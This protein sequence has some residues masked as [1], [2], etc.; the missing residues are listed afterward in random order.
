MER[1]DLQLYLG[2]RRSNPNRANRNTHVNERAFRKLRGKKT[3]LMDLPDHEE[4]KELDSLPPDRLRIELLKKGINPYKDIS[5]RVW[6]EAQTTTSSF[7]AVI[8]PYV[9]LEEKLPFWTN[10]PI[11]NG[12]AKFKELTQ[13]G[14]H[15]WHT[16]RNGTRR[17]KNKEGFASFS[18]KTFGPTAEHVYVEAHKALMARNRPELL[19]LITEHAFQKMWPDVDEGSIKW[20]LVE[21]LEPHQVV[22]VRCSDMPYQSGNDIAQVTVRMHTKQKLALY[23]RFGKLILGSETQPREVVE[24]VVFENHIAVVDGTW[25]L[26]DKDEDRPNSAHSSKSSTPSERSPQSRKQ[27][28][29]SSDEESVPSH[30]S[31]SNSP[32]NDH[33]SP[34]KKR[35]IETSDEEDDV[36]PKQSQ[37][38]QLFGDDMS[39]SN[40][41]ADNNDLEEG[42][43]QDHEGTPPDG[44]EED[45]TP[46]VI[47]A[48]S[49][50]T[51]I[52]LGE[53]IVFV[54]LPNF[55]SLEAKAFDPEDFS[56][57]EEEL[58]DEEGRQRLKLK[59]ENTIRWRKVAKE[60]GTEQY[61]SNSKIVKWSDGTMSLYLGGEIFDIEM[62][63]MLDHNHLYLRQGAG[64]IGQG[65]FDERCTFRPHSTDSK[66]HRKVTMSMAERTR[67]GA[68][69]KMIADSGLN[70]EKIR[71][72]TVRKEEE[73][74]RQA[75]RAQFA[76]QARGRR[77]RDFR[78]Y[79]GEEDD[80]DPESLSSIKR[81]YQD[82][83]IIGPSESESETESNRGDNQNNSSDSDAEFRRNKAQRKKMIVDDDSD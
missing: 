70:P 4:Q 17:I 51:D 7:Y 39:S 64:L 20:E 16:Y 5:P 25:R 42:R 66:T 44:E 13:A 63:P 36:E 61:E 38:S 9:T 59:L 27:V 60:D 24:Y 43:E 55:L 37:D 1:Q 62:R 58:A 67:K 57:S 81:R 14:L 29:I 19:K 80:Y 72:E 34:T 26:H 40:S 23:D 45:K 48:V 53:K 21:V 79:H 10:Q 22:S 50:K 32:D 69:I 68:Q 65:V 73:R 33:I 77:E 2:I 18:K 46:A 8:D 76:T 11:D 41:E 31:P 83:P 12:K 30:R 6:Q 28:P 47:Q 49:S 35:V 78:T 15:R 75:I 74:Y 52:D 54:K 71:Q 3:I 56:D 82:A